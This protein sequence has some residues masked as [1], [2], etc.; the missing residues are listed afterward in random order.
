V[1]LTLD[2]SVAE[3]VIVT[4]S[5]KIVLH[6][7]LAVMLTTGG[8]VSEVNPVHAKLQYHGAPLSGPLSQSSG[9][10][11]IPFQQID[12]DVTTKQLGV[13]ALVRFI[14]PVMLGE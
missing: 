3:T 5:T 9:G 8:V 6:A 11:G 2:G 13:T 14:S 4:E 1:P 12:H 7:P 10:S